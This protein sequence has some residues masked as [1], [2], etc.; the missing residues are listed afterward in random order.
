[1]NE[2]SQELAI[3]RDEA[4]FFY[5]ADGRGPAYAFDGMTF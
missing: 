3:A 1:M 5:G 2:A 4:I